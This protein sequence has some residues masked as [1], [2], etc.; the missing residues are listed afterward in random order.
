M[1][2]F[3]ESEKESDFECSAPAATIQQLRPI[4]VNFFFRVR[5][6]DRDQIDWQ[7]N[8]AVDVAQILTMDRLADSCIG[9][10]RV[11]RAKNINNILKV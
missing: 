9:V 10:K 5:V 1:A 4:E 3:S 7:L 11:F 2:F 8:C 6:R